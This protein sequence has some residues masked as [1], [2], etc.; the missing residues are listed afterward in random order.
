MSQMAATYQSNGSAKNAGY[1]E[2][3]HY[4]P[5]QRTGRGGRRNSHPLKLLAQKSSV[6]GMATPL[7]IQSY[8]SKE[9]TDGY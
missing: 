6:E 9:K 1:D 8:E 3:Y 2:P 4:R 5:A 7:E